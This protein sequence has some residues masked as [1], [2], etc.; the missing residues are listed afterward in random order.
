MRQERRTRPAS[1]RGTLAWPGQ[2]AVPVEAVYVYE[3]LSDDAGRLRRLL[4][5]LDELR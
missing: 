3:V 1:A 5:Q 4:R 2:V